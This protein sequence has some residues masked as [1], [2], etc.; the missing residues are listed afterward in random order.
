MQVIYIIQSIDHRLRSVEVFD[1]RGNYHL[2]MLDPAG[3]NSG[4]ISQ[5]HPSKVNT[6][7]YVHLSLEAAEPRMVV[8]PPKAIAPD[9]CFASSGR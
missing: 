7:D 6:S 2:L 3:G 8:K 4:R 5:P 1:N 9:D